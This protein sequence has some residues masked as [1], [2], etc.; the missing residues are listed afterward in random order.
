MRIKSDP[1][2][3]VYPI[4]VNEVST[5]RKRGTVARAARLDREVEGG[6]PNNSLRLDLGKTR[7]FDADG[8]QAIARALTRV[9]HDRAARVIGHDKARARQQRLADLEQHFRIADAH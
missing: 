5:H 1:Q 2:P 7:R 3:L 4:I 6:S 9:A 8:R